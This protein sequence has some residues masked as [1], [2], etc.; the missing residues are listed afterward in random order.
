M[1]GS[2]HYMVGWKPLTLVIRLLK[3]SINRAAGRLNNGDF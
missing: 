3:L 2:G 1:S